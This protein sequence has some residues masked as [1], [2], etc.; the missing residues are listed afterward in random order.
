M[1]RPAQSPNWPL[2]IACV[3]ASAV[4]AIAL[5][6]GIQVGRENH[7]GLIPVVRRLLDPAYL[8]G[9]FG[10]EI[11][12]HHH[13][14]FAL[15]VAAL[16]RPFGETGAFVALT[17]AGYAL[18][19]A[20]LWTLGAAL[21]LPRG[22][23]LLLAVAL[24]TGFAF[25][26]HGV[27]ANR[28]LGNGP[29]MPPTF[30]HAGIVFAVA[31]L[32]RGR[33]NLA[34][35]LSGAVALVHLQIGGIWL[36]AMLIEA[37]RQGV[38]RRPAAWLPGLL[39]ALLIASPALLD[40][41]ALARQGLT[42]QMG[43]MQDVAFRMPQHFQFHGNRVAAVLLYLGLF[44]WLWRHWRKRGDAR[45]A[46]FAPLLSLAVILMAFTA[47]HY[48]DYYLLGTGWISRIQL[49][50]LS[51]FVPVLSAFALLS[52]RLPGAD[53]RERW[54]WIVAA[55]FA[56]GAMAGYVRKG[57]P[58]SL[59]VVDASRAERDWAQACDWL[60][61]QGPRV[62]YASPPGHTGFTACSNRSTLVEFKINPDGGAGRAQWL[63]RLRAVAGG[64]L[65]ASSSRAGVAEALDA[66]YARL[67][68]AG[69]Q[70]LARDYGVGAA[71]VP[72]ASPLRGEVLYRN[73]GYR[74]VALAAPG[75][76]P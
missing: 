12:A 24:A 62:L 56:L 7:A 52:T 45:A 6:Q 76:A 28:F 40:L 49:L 42:R 68:D 41:A 53:G 51:V 1:F 47:L 32:A 14:I 75:D 4:L 37:T 74:V 57:E 46:A 44:A 67:P 73:A 33:W 48:A 2:T 50:R 17:Y 13:R 63:Q 25:L 11:R 34:F 60:R 3:F 70:A 55:L 21:A 61:A 18:M 5:D 43:A 38:W 29:I 71:L 20:A 35:A 9:D 8:P 23:R 30:A 72:A 69:F 16:A 39:A 58:P 27:E 26:D 65:P 10:I 36:A 66:A 59:R 64:A 31:A 19:F 15:M 22:R 54:P